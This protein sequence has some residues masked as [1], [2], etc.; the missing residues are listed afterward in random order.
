LSSLLTNF[1][2]KQ[3]FLRKAKISEKSNRKWQAFKGDYYQQLAYILEL[4]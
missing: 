1:Q 2:E 3:K 4:L